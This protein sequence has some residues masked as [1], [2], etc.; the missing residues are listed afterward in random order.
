MQKYFCHDPISQSTASV[1]SALTRASLSPL[2][3]VLPGLPTQPFSSDPPVLYSF[4][5]GNTPLPWNLPESSAFGSTNDRRMDSA[6]RSRA[7][8]RSTLLGIPPSPFS[9]PRFA[10]LPTVR[11]AA[12]AGSSSGS[13]SRQRAA[14]PVRNQPHS[15]SLAPGRTLYQYTV[16]IHPEPVCFLNSK[17]S[18]P[19]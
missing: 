6:V 13:R 2:S 7:G 9:V 18:L 15:R 17:Y 19:F 4:N 12:F 5:S 1:S 10:M 8:P 11:S 14:G 3:S 16:I